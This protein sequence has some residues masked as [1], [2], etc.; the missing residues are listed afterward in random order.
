MPYRLPQ[1]HPEF[2]TDALGHAVQAILPIDEY[3]K[4]VELVEDI[5][6]AM[7]LEEAADQVDAAVPFAE[8]VSRLRR[9]GVVDGG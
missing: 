7:A 6:D 4:M 5:E 1:L 3:Q 2:V 8:I 9:D